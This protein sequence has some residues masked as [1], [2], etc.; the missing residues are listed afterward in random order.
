MVQSWGPGIFENNLALTV[1]HRYHQLAQ[2]T[3][4]GY[5]AFEK[6]LNEYIYESKEIRGTWEIL[7]L[8]SLGIS[9]AS[10]PED[11]KDKA[12]DAINKEM[13]ILDAWEEPEKRRK[14]LQGLKSLLETVEYVNGG[15][16]AEYERGTKL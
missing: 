6:L 10:L 16:R 15:S 8:A 14:A 4:N 9:V 1:R 13:E 11:L 7:A 2:E 12:I 3:I 5:V